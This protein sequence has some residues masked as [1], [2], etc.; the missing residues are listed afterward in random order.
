MKSN[1]EKWDRSGYAELMREENQKQVELIKAANCKQ[2]KDQRIKDQ[3][4][5]NNLENNSAKQ[6]NSKKHPNKPFFDEN[7]EKD[8]SHRPLNQQNKQNHNSFRHKQRTDFPTEN[9]SD[10]KKSETVEESHFQVIEDTH[11]KPKFYYNKG[12]PKNF[13]STNNFNKNRYRDNQSNLLVN[14][15]FRSK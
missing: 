9:F 10:K 8:P 6:G 2:I 13:N 11:P 5:P 1:K 7:F 15:R 14:N 3:P 12:N 4:I